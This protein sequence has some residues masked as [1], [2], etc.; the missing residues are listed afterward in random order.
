MTK[1][2]KPKW[3]KDQLSQRHKLIK[4]LGQGGQGV[5][6]QTSDPQLLVKMPLKNFEEITDPTEI[7]HFQEQLERLF[8]LPLSESMHITKPLYLL[9]GQ[10]GYVMQ[11]MQD[12]KPIGEWLPQIYK[13]QASD[14]SKQKDSGNLPPPP[15]LPDWISPEVPKA[16]AYPL[17]MYA[18]SGGTK[19]RLEL[20]TQA[21]I[22]L[23]KLHSV[24]V[25][26]MDISPENLFCSKTKG[27]NEVWLIDA[28][29]LRFEVTNAKAGVL[30]PQYAAPEVVKGESGARVT[31]DAYSLSLLAFKILT[32]CGA[33]E[34]E[35]F[36][37]DDDDWAADDSQNG[38]LSVETQAEHGLLPFIFDAE[39]DSN[40]QIRGRGLPHQLTLTPE[41]LTFF[42]EMFGIGRTQPW[43]RPS[44][45]SLPRM[46]AK[47]TDNSIQC[48]CGMSF[49]YQPS[50]ENNACP[51]CQKQPQN[52]LVATSYQ[53]SNDGIGEP[54]WTWVSPFSEDEDLKLPRRLAGSFEFDKHS[55]PLLEIS[56]IESDS[57]I[58]ASAEDVRIDIT[59]LSGRFTPLANQWLL[60]K[61]QLE[62]GV[63]LYVHNPHSVLIEI[64][65][66]DNN[67]I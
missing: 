22:E 13:E 59:D 38:E 48:S 6:Y 31:S 33:F 58:Y 52:L 46:L 55:V 64:K 57:F 2:T 32:M 11:M 9:D 62:E 39:D 29:N 54:I 28:D 40:T 4:K 5:V 25:I 3:V 41:L 15:W 12:M 34:G 65:V 27:Y 43:Q 7:T 10:A 8:L 67:A 50:L 66:L 17:A 23:L 30:T 61:S 51:Y 16:S 47:A 42:Q 37:D 56:H 45:H 26:F 18:K 24:G 20:L 19:R 36:T 60:E 35:R 21:T 44:L 49:Y 14:N 63:Q 1:H 53:Y